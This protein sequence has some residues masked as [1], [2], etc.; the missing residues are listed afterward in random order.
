MTFSFPKVRKGFL[1]PISP[2]TKPIKGRTW[3]I[4]LFP[5]HSMVRKTIL[6]VQH[7]VEGGGKALLSLSTNWPGFFA[8]ICSGS[9]KS[10]FSGPVNLSTLNPIKSRLPHGTNPVFSHVLKCMLCSQSAPLA[11]PAIFLPSL[12]PK[13]AHYVLCAKKYDYPGPWLY[14]G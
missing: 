9:S 8:P 2:C 13:V 3:Y 11:L 1:H 10:D 4:L 12:T 14:W 6:V 7:P 5:P